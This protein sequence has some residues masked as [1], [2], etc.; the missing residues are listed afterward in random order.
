M[1][2]VSHRPQLWFDR[3]MAAGRTSDRPWTAG[4]RA[5]S[6]QAIVRALAVSEADW[7]DRGHVH[8]VKTEVSNVRQMTLSHAERCR[9]PRLSQRA[10]EY[11][12]P[13][14]KACAR[15]IGDN[16]QNL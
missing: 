3:S 7:V 6:R 9:L 13:C 16:L 8:H 15:A 12:V 1:L 5:V 14:A 4:R 11:F 2:E 10:R